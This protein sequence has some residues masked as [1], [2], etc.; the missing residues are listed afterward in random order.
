MRT[1]WLQISVFSLARAKVW[2]KAQEVEEERKSLGADYD[3]TSR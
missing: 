2:F 3:S 1:A